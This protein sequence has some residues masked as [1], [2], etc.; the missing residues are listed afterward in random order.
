MLAL[1]LRP[2]LV[3]GEIVI[4]PAEVTAGFRCLVAGLPRVSI[5]FRFLSWLIG[6]FGMRRRPGKATQG[7]TLIRR[8]GFDPHNPKCA[9]D[10]VVM[11]AD[12]DI[13]AG[14][15]D[16]VAKAIAAFVVIGVII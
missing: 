11:L 3:G 6:L 4:A 14:R 13:F 2:F 7:R 5:K 8:Q 16:V 12:R 15:K 9:Q 1:L 10:I